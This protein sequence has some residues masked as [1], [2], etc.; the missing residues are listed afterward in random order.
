M[1]LPKWLIAQD[2]GE[3][4]ERERGQKAGTGNGREEVGEE[5]KAAQG[6]GGQDERSLEVPLAHC[7]ADLEEC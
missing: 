1:S 2:V 5:N 6:E 4:G 7:Q 3:E